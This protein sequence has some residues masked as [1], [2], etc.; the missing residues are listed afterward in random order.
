MADYA[1]RLNAAL[2]LVQAGSPD[3]YDAL[4]ALIEEALDSLRRG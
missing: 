4:G 2:T 1:H 3:G